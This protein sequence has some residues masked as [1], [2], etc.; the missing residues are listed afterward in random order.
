MSWTTP[1]T[2]AVGDILSSADMNTY[3]RDNWLAL[4]KPSDNWPTN[5]LLKIGVSTATTDGGGH[6]V[7]TF[8]TP[9]PNACDWATG[10]G[11][12]T[13][14]LTAVIDSLSASAIDV[15]FNAAGVVRSFR[16]IAVGH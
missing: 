1:K 16:W 15:F 10:C 9:F 5:P 4:F 7:I 13:N 12:D 3:V 11:G 8:P 2:W 6:V 14:S